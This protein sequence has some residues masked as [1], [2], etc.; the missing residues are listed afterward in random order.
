MN[1]DAEIDNPPSRR[2]IVAVTLSALAAALFILFAAV[3][4]AEYGHDPTGLGRLT[5][6]GR[7]WTPGENGVRSFAPGAGAA[8]A[9][10]FAKPFRSNIVEIPLA[11]GGHGKRGDEI[12]YKVHLAEG[13][14]FVYSWAVDGMA[15]PEELYSEFHGH[16]LGDGAMT[17]AYY[18]KAAGASDNGVFTA[19]FAGVHGWLFQ[20]QSDKAVTVRLRLAGFYD[21][22]PA[23]A[24]GNE[25]RLEARPV[26]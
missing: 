21:L 13:A 9:A 25:A 16:T 18:R 11:V 26:R 14:A 4:P 10:S 20:N 15:K 23:G 6:I 1:A 24:P 17:V 3:L 12:E 19:P 7:L 2:R 8:P 5:G 22:V